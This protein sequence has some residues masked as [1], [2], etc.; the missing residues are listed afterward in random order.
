MGGSA[1]RSTLGQTAFPRLPPSVYNAL[2][3]RLQSR[4][5]ELY[6]YVSVP[7]EA[8]QKEDYGDLDFLVAEP[9]FQ[10]SNIAED[11]SLLAGDSEATSGVSAAHALV[12]RTL[13]AKHV[14]PWEGN[15]TS[16]Y[17][18]PVQLGEWEA[19]GEGHLEMER[20][21]EAPNSEIFYQVRDLYRASDNTKRPW[22]I[23]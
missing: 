4:I 15:R 14:I 7:K 22:M 9:K 18:V 23:C 11:P 20:R 5:S 2:K 8:P 1:F 10:L 19:F 16:N 12:K 21:T 3:G 13:L 17:A 6:T